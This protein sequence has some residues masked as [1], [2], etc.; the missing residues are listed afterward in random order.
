MPAPPPQLIWIDPGGMT[1]MAWLF[2]GISYHFGAGEYPFGE[3]CEKLERYCQSWAGQFWIGYEKFTILPSTHKL[4]PQ[5]EAYEFPGVIKFL[6]A[7][8][9]CTLLQP[10]QPS[11]RLSA[12]PAELKALA[13]MKREHCLSPEQARILAQLH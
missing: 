5:P 4:S 10:A 13:W 11:E 12:T 1:G 2:K 8:Y 7:R 3:A 6:A 9:R